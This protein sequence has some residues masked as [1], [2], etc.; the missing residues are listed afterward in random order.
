MGRKFNPRAKQGKYFQEVEE[1]TWCGK[2]TSEERGIS[3][4][5]ERLLCNNNKLVWE[6]CSAIQSKGLKED[7]TTICK[8][9]MVDTRQNARQSSKTWNS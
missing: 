3:R 6:F 1:N 5:Q 2:T 9:I 7:L 8:Y 4:G